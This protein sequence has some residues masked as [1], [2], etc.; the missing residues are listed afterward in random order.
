MIDA[1]SGLVEA[2]AEDVIRRWWSGVSSR[3]KLNS[4]HVKG[5]RRVWLACQRSCWIGDRVRRDERSLS[6]ELRLGGVL[7]VF[8]SYRRH[9]YCIEC[10]SIKSAPVIGGVY[11]LNQ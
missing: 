1:D 10:K 11:F 9:G 3:V 2:L 5:G 8:E 7:E 4:T 6:R